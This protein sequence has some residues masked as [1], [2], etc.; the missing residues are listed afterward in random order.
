MSTSAPVQNSYKIV[1]G[2]SNDK[3]LDSY[4]Y[5]YDPGNSVF[6]D[7]H[8]M[9]GRLNFKVVGQIADARY[10][11]GTPG[12]WNIELRTSGETFVGYYD[13]RERKGSLTKK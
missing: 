4:K 10:E 12:C 13:A 8:L 11:S 5:V 9:V 7:F 3:V 2:P 6:V 1:D